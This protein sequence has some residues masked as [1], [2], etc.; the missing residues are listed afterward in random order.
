[1]IDLFCRQILPLLFDDSLVLVRQFPHVLR[2]DPHQVLDEFVAARVIGVRV[3]EPPLRLREKR[4]E[5]GVAP[6]DVPSDPFVVHNR[7]LRELACRCRGRV[8][9]PALA[10]RR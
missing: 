2:G 8:T 3:G 6:E 7:I 1:M 9:V 5:I 10:V 4:V